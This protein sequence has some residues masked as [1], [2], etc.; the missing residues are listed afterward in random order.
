MRIPFHRFSAEQINV[1]MNSNGLM[2]VIASKESA[3]DSKRNGQRKTTVIVEETCQ[4]PGYVV[5]NELLDKVES[6]FERGCLMVRYPE[7][8]KIVEEREAKEAEE[9]A[10]TGPIEIPIMMD[11]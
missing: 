4:M 7:D 9:K 10:K 5:E 3:E 11:E 8:P 6:K 1:S 2:T